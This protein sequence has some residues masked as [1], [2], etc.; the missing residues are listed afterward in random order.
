MAVA[1]HNPNRFRSHPSGVALVD[2][3]KTLGF[4]RG[5]ALASLWQIDHWSDEEGLGTVLAYIGQE[6]SQRE[7][8]CYRDKPP[9]VERV[10]LEMLGN[11]IKDEVN[12]ERKL[13][14]FLIC[15]GSTTA[16][17]LA[18]RRLILLIGTEEAGEE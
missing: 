13:L 2:L 12:D 3:A 10:D 8:V 1:V 11:L 17:R 5:N 4:F 9:E 14:Y 7:I 6:I 16:L 15:E 18:E